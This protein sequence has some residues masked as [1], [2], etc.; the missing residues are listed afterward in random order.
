MFK[1]RINPKRPPGV[2][3]RIL[4]KAAVNSKVTEEKSHMYFYPFYK[5][6]DKTVIDK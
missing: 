5:L 4:A 1:N 3:S 2:L 6:N